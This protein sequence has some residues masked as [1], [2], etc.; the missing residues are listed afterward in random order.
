MLAASTS[1]AHVSGLSSIPLLLC[2][3]WETALSPPSSLPALGDYFVA[4]AQVNKALEDQAQ[5]VAL[6]ACTTGIIAPRRCS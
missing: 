2:L 1:R 6:S 3:Q 4:M 5:V